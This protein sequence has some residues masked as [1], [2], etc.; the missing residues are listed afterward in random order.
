MGDAKV[1][2]KTKGMKHIGLFVKNKNYIE[3]KAKFHPL[4]S[5]L[6]FLLIHFTYFFFPFSLISL[7]LPFLF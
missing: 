4:F 5:F 1:K 7:L 3:K 2:R 6:S